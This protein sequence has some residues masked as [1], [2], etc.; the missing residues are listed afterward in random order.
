MVS[1]KFIF[2]RF[3]FTLT[4]RFTPFCLASS[5]RNVLSYSISKRARSVLSL[6]KGAMTANS[7]PIIPV[8]KSDEVE[9]TADSSFQRNTT[10][11][12]WQSARP[13]YAV[14]SIFIDMGEIWEPIRWEDDIPCAIWYTADSVTESQVG[15][16]AVSLKE[17]RFVSPS[18]LTAA[19]TY[20]LTDLVTAGLRFGTYLRL[21]VFLL[22]G[23]YFFKVW[24]IFKCP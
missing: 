24:D 17:R 6:V 4:V 16:I 11:R 2:L 14:K 10:R 22:P 19:L 18:C 3:K 21:Y 5:R 15:A 9:I 12:R 1:E 20:R 23:M 13:R 7:V 8:S